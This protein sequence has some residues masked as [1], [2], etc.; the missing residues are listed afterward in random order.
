MIAKYAAGALLPF[1]FLL[2]LLSTTRLIAQDK[3]TLVKD[4]INIRGMV[5]GADHLPANVRINTHSKSVTTADQYLYTHTNTKG[6]FEL[7]GIGPNDT[8][9]IS[10]MH[11]SMQLPVKGARSLMITMP[12][13]GRLSAGKKTI[14]A[15]RRHPLTRPS[16]EIAIVKKDS[17]NQTPAN[18]IGNAEFPGGEL[19]FSAYIQDHLTYP[20]KAI[21]NNVEGTVVANFQ[22]EENGDIGGIQVV[23][24]LDYGCNDVVVNILKKSP[25]WKP[26]SYYGKPV[27]WR[28]YVIVEFKLKDQ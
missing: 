9:F 27:V 14:E 20:D 6:Y 25:R 10:T 13:Y 19:N 28:R 15:V 18:Y 24:G 16:F 22:I 12:N 3:V 11:T 7:K 1:T 2:Q 17:S 21:E 4:T 5:T 23:S 8:L 26:A